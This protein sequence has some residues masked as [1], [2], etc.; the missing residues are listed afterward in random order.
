MRL[1]SLFGG[2]FEKISQLAFVFAGQLDSYVFAG[3]HEIKQPFRHILRAGQM[4]E[5]VDALAYPDGLNEA[6]GV[7][8]PDQQMTGLAL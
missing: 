4:Q 3:G 8:I 6:L 1:A 5:N 7:E 2:P